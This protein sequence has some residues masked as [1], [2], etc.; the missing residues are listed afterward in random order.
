MLKFEMKGFK[1]SFSCNI[2]C[3]SL[4]ISFVSEFMKKLKLLVCVL[5]AILQIFS[6]FLRMKIYN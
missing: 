1:L 2:D 5:S 3:L 6:K 4:Q